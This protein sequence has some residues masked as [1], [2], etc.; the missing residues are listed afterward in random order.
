[1]EERPE[2]YVTCHG[3]QVRR[4]NG[5]EARRSCS[6]SQQLGT[7]WARTSGLAVP[8]V[9]RLS[10]STCSSQRK[11]TWNNQAC[12]R[13]ERERNISLKVDA[14]EQL[15]WEETASVSLGELSP[16][17]SLL[18]P[19]KEVNQATDRE[20]SC[21]SPKGSSDSGFLQTQPRVQAVGAGCVSER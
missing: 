6:L 15:S 8:A 19:E 18:P 1:M 21:W 11:H 10:L 12:E 20:G 13:R 7:S 4:T 14:E 3:Q 5:P 16:R 9:T 17:E 2:T